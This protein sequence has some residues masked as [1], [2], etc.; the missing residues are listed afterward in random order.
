MKFLFISDTHFAVKLPHAKVAGDGYDSDRIHDCERAFWHLIRYADRENVEAAFIL[1]DLFDVASP[2][3]PTLK[4]V[5]MLLKCLA[6]HTTVYLL[7]GNHDAHDRR[8][9]LYSLGL[10]DVLG[11]RRI[12]VL[13]REWISFG[14]H[15]TN[16]T[17]AFFS[18]PWIPDYD[19]AE[20]ISEA[21]TLLYN[22][23]AHVALIHQTIDGV[24]DRRRLS[25]PLKEAAFEGFDL[26]L[27]GHIHKP[28]ELGNVQYLGSPI[29]MSF[30]EADGLDRGFWVLDGNTLELELRPITETPTWLTFE[31]DADDAD[32]V[33]QWVTVAVGMG[34]K[35]GIFYTNPVQ[36]IVDA[37]ERDHLYADFKVRG[38]RE[39]V[40]RFCD[41]LDELWEWA[42]ELHPGHQS[43]GQIRLWRKAKIITDD[44]ASERVRE[45]ATSGGVATPAELVAAFV[46]AAGSAS[47]LPEGVEPEALEEFGLLALRLGD[48]T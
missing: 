6:E 14:G 44:G 20:V 38:T 33:E 18:L 2:D 41:A 3:M 27:S 22:A 4:L 45:A 37:L 46:E 42:A 25:S 17:I 5:G 11:L 10:F 26:V 23:D 24:Y 43:R 34:R 32:E 39:N 35:G 13:G 9:E 31:I 16:P 47:E 15:A 21:G 12:R 7:P 1:G 19:V 30:N 29:P 48:T 8:G 36:R 40:E 28:Q